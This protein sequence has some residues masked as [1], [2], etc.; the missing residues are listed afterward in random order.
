MKV[1]CYMRVGTKAQLDDIPVKKKLPKK[2]SRLRKRK[3]RR[4][5]SGKRFRIWSR[6]SF[7]KEQPYEYW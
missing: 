2:L 7:G 5:K 6:F 1:C 3:Q 4:N